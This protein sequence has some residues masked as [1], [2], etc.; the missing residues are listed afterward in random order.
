MGSSTGIPVDT[1]TTW[2]NDKCC[3]IME[4]INKPCFANYVID[5]MLPLACC[6]H[7]CKINSRW[8]LIHLLCCLCTGWYLYLTCVDEKKKM[9]ISKNMQ[10]K[11]LVLTA[12]CRARLERSSGI[13][14][15]SQAPQRY[16][17]S[18]RHGSELSLG[19]EHC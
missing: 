7:V 17:R 8:M 12:A 1:F 13:S 19:T 5:S 6:S 15:P 4:I 2:N 11:A 18:F 9:Y 3:F 10:R 14:V 16:S